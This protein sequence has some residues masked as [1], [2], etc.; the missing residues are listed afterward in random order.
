[1]TARLSAAER[2]NTPLPFHRLARRYRSYRWW[3]PLL[4]LVTTLGVWCAIVLVLGV[5]AVL[6]SLAAPGLGVS[7]DEALTA[8]GPGDLHDP[9][10]ALVML[11]M[12]AAG[13][14]AVLLGVRVGGWRP[15]GSV[16][17]V[18]GRLRW[19]LLARCAAVAVVLH[20]VVNTVGLLVA[21]PGEAPEGLPGGVLDG[22]PLLTG[23][24]LW[25]LLIAVLVVPFQAAAEE[26][27]FRGLLMQAIGSWLRHPAWA[28]L[29][30]A[31]L[32]VLGHAYDWAGQTDILV[33]ALAAGW[34]TWRTGGLEAA[35]G[36]HVVGNC[37]VFALGAF[38]LADLNATEIEPLAV[39]VSVGLT[40]AYTAIVAR[41]RRWWSRDAGEHDGG[42]AHDGG[43]NTGAPILPVCRTP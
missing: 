2:M 13:L 34:L 15:A 42:G 35:I 8:A 31:P 18:V 37:T 19:G 6:V 14:P 27:A 3:R 4:A 41:K 16:S 36:L 38:G 25:L 40:L 43:R 5:A 32:F 26:Y 7:L 10:T 33:F 17:S 24:G 30:P 9:A 22:G 21:P 12:L 11:L 39:V 1:M 28:I 29:L 23:Q 20:A